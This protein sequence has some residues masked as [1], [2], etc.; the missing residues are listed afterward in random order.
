[1]INFISKNRKYFLVISIC[2][3][4]MGGL[5]LEYGSEKDFFHGYSIQT[6]VIRIGLGVNLKNIE[7]TSSS[8]MKIYEV[9]THYELISEN[10]DEAY[11]KG[12]KDKLNEKYVVQVAYSDERE[13]AELMA[14]ELR[15]KVYHKV[16]ISRSSGVDVTGKFRIM[17]GDFSTRSD[18]LGF[19]ARL[20]EI[21]EYDPWIIREKITDEDSRPLWIMVGDKVKSL[22]ENTILYF[23]PSSYQSYLTYEGR[24]YRGIFVLKKGHQG[25]TLINTLNI[26]D[27]L[28]SVVP[29]ELSPYEFREPEAQKA[30]AVAARTYALKNIKLNDG[31]DFDLDDTPNS[32]FYTG[33]S[34]EHALTNEAVNQTKGEVAVYK[35]ELI[36]ALYTSTCGGRTENVE[37]VFMGPALP[38]LRSTEC[39]YESQKGWAFKT[40]K[41][42]LPHYSRSRNI[43]Y[44]IAVL[45]SMGILPEE[46][47]DFFKQTATYPEVKNWVHKAAQNLGLK[48]TAEL[49]ERDS[50]TYQNFTEMIVCLF[51][52]QKRV[53][54]LLLDSEKEFL[55]E[56]LSEW[57]GKDQ[58]YA[59][60]FIQ[61][62][63]YPSVEEIIDP[64][65]RM[66]YGEAAYYLWKIILA[67]GILYQ[68]GI[69]KEF[70]D[71]EVVIE[72]DYQ[73]IRYNLAAAANFVK[74]YEGE[75]TF[76]SNLQMVGDERVQFITNENKI[77]F[78]EVLYPHQTNVLDRKSSHHIWRVRKS[79]EE[80]SRRVN[81]FYPV[82]EVLD[83]IPI[84]RG[85][86]K[87][88][89]KIIVSGTD[90][91]AEV[92]GLRIRRVLG[93]RETNFVIDR[94]YS[95][96]GNVK[97]FT[98][99]GKG[100]G[101]GVGLCQVGAYGMARAGADYKEILKKYYQG[102]Y[103][104]NLY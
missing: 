34:A 82:G 58:F 61:S 42:V 88:I 59:A 5:P 79:A 100:W 39:T 93:L 94:E 33:M 98:F 36:E 101:H 90:S 46:G 23:I 25:I 30:Q 102:I 68:E 65:K 44:E 81:R 63:I 53:D 49:P 78:F 96:A 2:F 10:V 48:H 41:K 20:N 91:D 14:Q 12:K 1:M 66:T 55:T 87:R 13:E 60:Y 54:N 97:Y 18:A 35:G 64:N 6:P 77:V 99:N 104:K 67:Q 75:R 95:Q 11:I 85:D 70:S 62:G 16:F 9:G 15:N 74:N 89:S 86:S 4:L 29:S 45:T 92:R 28:K 24:D 52:W 103:L 72:K 51:D 69:F 40:S 7:I 83:I 71:D 22:D 31:H 84:E 57:K 27:Y 17:V 37:D 76:V 50:L 80:I 32:Q 43:S 47:P 26:E 21:G 19:I 56:E 38:Y 73:E 8:G 3:F